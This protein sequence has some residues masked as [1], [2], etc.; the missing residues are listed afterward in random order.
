[1][2]F[3]F[4][5]TIVFLAEIIISI[6]II[7]FLLRLDCK[8]NEINSLLTE[9]KPSVKD[10]S[11]LGRKISSQIVEL[12]KKYVQSYEQRRNEVIIRQVSSFILGILFF[13]RLKKSKGG[14]YLSKGL[15]LLQI[16]I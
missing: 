2:L 10:I 13:N 7:N 9:V 4:L 1:M 12:T 8:I 11:V 16:M 15:S 14:R 5:I 6:A 3:T